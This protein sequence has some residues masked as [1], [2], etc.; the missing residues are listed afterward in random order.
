MKRTV[1]IT[2]AASKPGAAHMHGLGA[3]INFAGLL[4][5]AR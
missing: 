4:D 2:G 3:V 1:L 5:W